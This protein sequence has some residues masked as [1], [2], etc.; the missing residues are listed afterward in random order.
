MSGYERHLDDQQDNINGSRNVLSKISLL[1]SFFLSSTPPI[2][3]TFSIP[4]FLSKKN[5]LSLNLPYVTPMLGRF[6]KRAPEPEP[7]SWAELLKQR[8]ADRMKAIPSHC[9]RQLDPILPRPAGILPVAAPDTP[10]PTDKTD[11]H[12]YATTSRFDPK[13]P[14]PPPD[15][16]RHDHGPD[17]VQWR[18]KSQTDR[19]AE[20]NAIIEARRLRGFPRVQFESSNYDLISGV[21]YQAPFTA[22]V[23]EIRKRRE[24]AH[25]WDTQRKVDPVTDR[26]PSELLES[27]RIAND[28][29]KRQRKVEY[30]EGKMSANERRAKKTL[31]NIVTGEV[32]DES[33]AAAIQEFPRGN[34][35]R[36]EIAIVR[37]KEIVRRREDRARVQTAKVGCR[38]NNGRMKEVRD[39]D[40]ISGSDMQPGWD[41]SVK[42]RPGVWDWCSTEGMKL[43]AEE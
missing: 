25:L 2:S 17:I 33:A 26:F 32:K 29:A 12:I 23:D 8:E 14:V 36:A 38:Y 11:L 21:P 9:Y 41:E 13:E 6:T 19:E 28:K 31:A 27:Q 5:P 15:V 16:P 39:W 42:M 22:R 1:F 30:F 43:N 3:L 20:T 35:K 40:I 24:A 18:E 7:K 37:E 34:P 4:S 10:P